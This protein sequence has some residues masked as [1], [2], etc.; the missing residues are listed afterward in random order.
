MSGCA[1]LTS[2]YQWL[3]RGHLENE[4]Q[5]CLH[6][7]L[8]YQPMS[9]TWSYRFHDL[10]T[11]SDVNPGLSPLPRAW[12]PLGD[13]CRRW[14]SV[15]CFCEAWRLLTVCPPEH[16]PTSN[17]TWIH[18]EG[19]LVLHPVHACVAANRGLLMELL[20]GVSGV[21]THL[22]VYRR[23]YTRGQKY[24]ELAGPWHKVTANIISVS[25]IISTA[26]SVN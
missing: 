8:C 12:N 2:I 13:S 24:W 26:E 15:A 11:L 22:M 25:H 7:R 4:L 16:N 10:Q 1:I 17:L 18:R 6:S 19:S 9:A 23:L 5:Y 20:D 14:L 21:K 3:I